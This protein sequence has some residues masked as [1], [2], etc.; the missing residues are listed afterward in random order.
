MASKTRVVELKDGQN[1]QQAANAHTMVLGFEEVQRVTFQQGFLAH[2]REIRQIVESY[3]QKGVAMIAL[4]G[5]K[6]VAF[7]CLAAKRS[8]INVAIIGRHGVA[9]LFLP[10][11]R[12]LSLR[13]L[14]VI[15]YP[16]RGRDE[17]RVRLVDLRTAVAFTDERGQ[18]MEA[19][20][21][22]GPLFFSVGR[23]LLYLFPTGEDTPWPDDPQ[24][25]WECIPERVYLA[26]T[27]AEPDRWQRRRIHDGGD[28]GELESD[29]S[30]LAGGI[31]PTATD[32]VDLA[33]LE[34]RRQRSRGGE[35][36]AQKRD[37]GA[38]SQR[39]AGAEPP[40]IQDGNQRS[41]AGEIGGDAQPASPRD[42][43]PSG[44]AAKVIVDTRSFAPPR[45][46]LVQALSGPSRARRSLLGEE[47]TPLGALRVRS[48]KGVSTIIVGPRAAR[49][50]A[51][52]GR[53]DRCDNE[54]LT[55]LSN[56]RIS[57]VHMLLIEI[58]GQLYA[59]DAA[60]TNG[61]WVGEQERRVVPL[62]FGKRWM[63]GDKLAWMEWLIVE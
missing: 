55:V 27:P 28:G 54:G 17:P 49:E 33:A 31:Q 47:E 23:Y 34:A 40:P 62:R 59:I 19:V 53:Y 43:F 12:S 7:A 20:E 21:A 57:R 61:I 15:L 13:H 26:D 42:A 16:Q 3:D 4:D 38:S 41:V 37:A 48:E 52:F 58:A 11:D 6:V 10:D 44:G 25:G 22:E 56:G 30:S 24:A 63:L 45:R 2:Y 1:R 32:V 29:G 14:V 18:R 60:S 51:L 46:T 5:P 9:D 50:G 39:A 35:P 36:P 8:R